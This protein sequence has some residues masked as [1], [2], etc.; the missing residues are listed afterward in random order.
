MSNVRIIHEVVYGVSAL[1]RGASVSGILGA[2]AS[3]LRLSGGIVD[4]VT[5]PRAT[6]LELRRRRIS[7]V[8]Y[9][10][11]TFNLQ[12]G[13]IQPNGRLRG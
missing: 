3:G 7:T 2:P 12:C 9:P 4:G 1:V 10:S 13:I 6:S 11:T 8:W 5:T